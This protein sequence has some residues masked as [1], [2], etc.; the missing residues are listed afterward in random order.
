[1]ATVMSYSSI[2]TV[3]DSMALEDGKTFTLGTP[4][5]KKN[6]AV[7]FIVKECGDTGEQMITEDCLFGYVKIDRVNHNKQIVSG[8]F[9]FN[10]RDENDNLFRMFDG[11]FDRHYTN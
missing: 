9:D 2:T 6:Y 8:S 11:V 4:D 5:S 10:V 7:F 3:L 1:M